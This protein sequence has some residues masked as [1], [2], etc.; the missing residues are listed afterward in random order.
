MY[1][2]SLASAFPRE[3]YTQ[4]ECWDIIDRS[5]ECRALKPRSLALL[6]RVLTA[7]SGIEKRHFVVEPID[8]IF[9]KDA[10][11]QNREFQVSAPRLAGEALSEALERAGC[12]ASDL[13]ALFVCTCTGYLCPGVSSYIAEELDIPGHAFL[14][15]LAGL[16]CGAAIP[17][18]RSA[19]NFLNSHPEATVGVVA[20]EVCSG[21][22]YVDN[23]PGVLISLCLF[24]DGASASIWTGKSL[25]GKSSD[26]PQWKAGEFQTLHLPEHREK[27]RFVNAGG[28]LKN[29]L[30]RSV[31]RL[32][33][34]A[35]HRL[36]H[37]RNGTSLPN[38][39]VITHNGGRDVIEAIREKLP[40]ASLD[41][42]AGVLRDYGNM[43]SPSVLVALQRFLEAE[44][45][46]PGKGGG[47][48]DALWLS[49]FG[50]GFS[51]HACQL[52]RV[53]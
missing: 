15:D 41:A 27:I 53:S 51:A 17:T 47:A 9:A 26:A 2:Q 11:I 49:A 10:E 52:V 5:E 40:T 33:G 30:H 22:F 20:V 39:E 6:E 35:V 34:D 18:L 28:Q 23:D 21:A 31:P 8:K 3:S 16:G 12:R 7:D 46:A 1:L 37:S 14:Q 45:H 13:D 50:A 48:R 4:R 25:E 24:G 42:T 32:T 36:F 19:A 29:Q 44:A 43:S 38:P